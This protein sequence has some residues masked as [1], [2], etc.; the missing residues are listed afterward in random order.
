VVGAV[1]TPTHTHHKSH[2]FGGNTWF[3]FNII[4]ITKDSFIPS[5]Y[6]QGEIMRGTIAEEAPQFEPQLNKL[7]KDVCILGLLAP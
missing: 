5:P 1:D 6:P 4:E 3:I 2:W 7:E